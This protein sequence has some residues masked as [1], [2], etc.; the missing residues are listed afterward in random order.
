M[1]LIFISKFNNEKIIKNIHKQ[2]IRLT[3]SSNIK[4]MVLFESSKDFNIINEILLE[5]K[6]KNSI[7]FINIDSIK[8]QLKYQNDY[9]E[10]YIKFL[11]IKL[12]IINLNTGAFRSK[13]INQFET[14]SKKYNIKLLFPFNTIFRGRASLYDSIYLKSYE[15]SK[16]F[17]DTPN[18]L[19]PDI[20]TKCNDYIK[21]YLEFEDDSKVRGERFKKNNNSHLNIFL[22]NILFS[23]LKKK[24]KSN[25]CVLLLPKQN[26][27]Y[28]SYANP[29]NNNYFKLINH[30]RKITPKE[31][32]LVV[33]IHPKQKL[34]LKFLLFFLFHNKSILLFQEN[35]N[36][37]SNKNLIKESHLVFSAGTTAVV[38]PILLMK[39][40]IEIGNISY[41]LW[42]NNSPFKR[43][44]IQNKISYNK[45]IVLDYIRGKNISN[46]N[47]LKY[48]HAFL[49]T[50]FPLNDKHN[51]NE[52]DF[53][54]NID[55]S[56]I[57]INQIVKFII[58][59]QINE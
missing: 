8:S 49:L 50:S 47:Y 20:I 18:T 3:D 42:V 53:K 29:E 44:N 36:L 32:I 31:F 15:L 16:I 43:I 41:G 6:H 48:I 26:N 51:T 9:L 46:I 7:N 59:S 38:L 34:S 37:I 35:L 4:I 28:N 33:K 58:K 27:W 23:N 10:K 11:N 14:I 19:S 1:I 55:S 57:M 12:L 39:K 17:N 2:L 13:Y 22:Q 5:A 52:I 25:Y 21:K 56:K 24:I 45:S 30:I 40:I 54:K